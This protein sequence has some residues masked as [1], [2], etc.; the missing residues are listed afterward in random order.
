MAN[1]KK[2]VINICLNKGTPKIGYL[3]FTNDCIYLL[4]GYQ[5]CRSDYKTNLRPLLHSHK[6]DN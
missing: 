3:K 5:K 1:Q 6:S 2:S 4:Q